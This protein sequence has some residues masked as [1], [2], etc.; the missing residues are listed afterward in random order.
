MRDRDPPDFLASPQGCEL[1]QTSS[2]PNSK[3]ST[4]STSASS[5]WLQ[6]LTNLP[7]IAIVLI[8]VFISIYPVFWIFISSLKEQQEFTT[9][10]M[11]ALPQT[12]HWENYARAWSEGHMGT[13]FFNSVVT[14]FPSLMIVIFLGVSAAFGIEIMQWRYANATALLFLA[15]IMVPL[16]I[17]ILPL[18]TMYFSSH[19]LNTHLALI[20]TYVAFGLPLVVFFMAGYFKTFSR[21]VIEAAIVDGA[22]IYQ[23]FFKIALPMVM[24][25]VVTVA[26]VQFF[27][28]WNDLLVSLTFTT[29]PEM[30]TVQ[31]GLLNFAGQY[32]QREWGPTF[33]SVAITVAPTVIVYL[34]LNQLVMKGLASGAVKG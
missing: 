10:P 18:F 29:S 9:A 2:P 8:A 24:N 26:L 13:Y 6:R 20:I 23:V 3:A 28:M 4:S 27:F 1:M 34:F 21:E 31:S 16:Q 30:R 15:A 17:V 5:L 33:A 19:L 14:V 12:L 32:G 7:V 25:A 11:W 22:S